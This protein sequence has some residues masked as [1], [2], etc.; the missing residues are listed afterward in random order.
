MDINEALN[1]I[2]LAPTE[3]KIYLTLLKIG[4]ATVVKI[5]KET[6]LHRRTIYD[7]LNILMHKGLVSFKIIN[8]IK[9]FEASDPDSLKIFIE[10]KN[11]ILENIL[12][13]L[14]SH[15]KKEFD[16]P[17]INIF[18]GLKGAK[19]L[20]EKAINSNKELLW[21]GGGAHLF[22]LLGFSR[23]FIEKKLSKIK[24]KTIQPK[25]TQTHNLKFIKKENIKYLPK[26]FTSKT[27]YLVYDN[28]VMIG[29]IHD[30]EITTIEINSKECSETYTKY[31][32]SLW[33]LSNIKNQS[34]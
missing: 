15:Y 12:P 14:K 10:E 28:I 7:N 2:G 33:A 11:N 13:T 18:I 27:G 25:T 29:I 21:V 22:E 4:E 19:T 1:K 34:D 31:F 26:S 6:E 9:Y 32:N 5:A 17:E 16:K 8:N 20:I 30:K 24:I 23:N 3:T